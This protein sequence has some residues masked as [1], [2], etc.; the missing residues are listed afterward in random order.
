MKALPVVMAVTGAAV[1]GRA[2][3]GVIDVPSGQKVQFLD[4]IWGQPGPDGLTVRFRFVAPAIAREGGTVP[5]DV[6][7]A[8]MAHLCETYALPR[9]SGMGPKPAQ[10]IISLSDRALEFGAAAP[11]AT[12][13]FEA[14][15]PEDGTCAWEGF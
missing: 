10:I 8:D 15:R 2:D 5:F 11:E 12:Q 14:Y 6:A 7:E 9:L 13:Y 3:E 1:Q 4:T